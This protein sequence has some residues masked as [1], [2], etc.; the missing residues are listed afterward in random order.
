M[1]RF[2]VRKSAVGT[3][4]AIILIAGAALA[5][6]VLGQSTVVVAPGR[7]E[8]PAPPLSIGVA[9]A[10]TVAEILVHEGSRVHAGDM[11]LKLNCAPLE[12]DVHAREAQARAA[13]ANFD[14]VRNGPRP[15]EIAVGQA[16]VR[17]SQARA[18]EAQK[19][20]DRTEALQEG[21]TVT[22]ARI[23]EVQR[24]ARIAAAQ[25]EEARAR[26]SLLRAGSREEDIR[27]SEAL[28]DAAAAEVQ[29]THVRLD[30]C[31]VHAPVDG[32]VLDV[33]AN[34]GEYISLAVP[35][36]LLHILPDGPPR[37][38]AEVELRDIGK[39]CLQQHATVGAEAF[40]NGSMQAQVV[41]ISPAVS[42]RTT[43]PPA[44]GDARDQDILPVILSLPSGTPALP[45]GLPVT[46]R[47]DACPSK[48]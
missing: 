20:L 40:A 23:L 5:G 26:L 31:V 13:Q 3:A 1:Q 11:L 2:T 15:D 24:D 4:L 36:P 33:A 25:L 39:L 35:Q 8:A 34:A 12:A 45:T 7:S 38:R 18:E 47:F 10:G 19:T 30:Q 21:V 17:Y 32:T 28:R 44:A 6:K 37:V 42:A 27:Q 41:A 43:A 14:R 48:T 22:T 9:A 29:A 16:V 46:V